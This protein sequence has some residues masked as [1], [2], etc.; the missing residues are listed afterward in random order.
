ML[1]SGAGRAGAEAPASPWKTYV[2]ARAAANM[3]ASREAA[4]AYSEALSAAPQS[5]LLAGRTFQEAVSA[6]DRKLALQA[7]RILEKHGELPA[8]ARLMLLGE[9]LR[10]RDWKQSFLHID[11]IEK[12]ELF[13]FMAPV[14]RAWTALGA[15]RGD[16]LALLAAANDNPLAAAYAGDQRPLLLLATGHRDQ[17]LTELLALAQGNALFEQRLRIAGAALLARR[18]ERSAALRLVEGEGQ[19]LAAVRALIESGARVPGEI[20]TPTAGIGA[21]F[22]RI[23]VDLQRQ[24]IPD[25]A[26]RMARL[27]T[28]YA[29]DNSDVW[30]VA[31]ELLGAADRPADAIAALDGVKP[32]DPFAPVAKDLRIRFLV[33]AGARQD[34]LAEALVLTG[35][36][37]AG[38]SDWTRLGLLYAELDRPGEAAE[39]FARA[40]A[41]RGPGTDEQ[42]EWSLR[43]LRGGALEQADRWAE[44]KAELQAAYRLAPDQAE[45][46]NNLGFG[47]LERRENVEEATR[48][49]AEASRL[50][51]DS[52]AITDS[53]GWAHFL[54]GELPKAVELLERAAAAAP[55]DPEI[56]EHLGD[57]YY[58]SGRRFEARYAWKAALVYAE[59]KDAERIAAKIEAGLTAELVS[60]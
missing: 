13:G 46:L 19:A 56:N 26:V 53:L 59:G 60:P 50:A 25:L 21:L 12:D 52:P 11:R 27:A 3:G 44:A 23:A 47:Q 41:V 15:R 49:I 4:R 40:L 7:A 51:P 22:V 36:A 6:G 29:P 58:S 32:S 16:P 39:A 9:T 54:R 14:L 34:A 5:R 42:P 43:L 1:A 38:A 33:A 57:A 35:R 31:A 2:Q 20:A 17:G 8:D 37:G 10:K 45:V 30:L 48:L 18:N 24:R 55:S 28:F